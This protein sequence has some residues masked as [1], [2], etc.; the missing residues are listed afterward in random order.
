VGRAATSAPPPSARAG[1]RSPPHGGPSWTGTALRAIE[2]DPLSLDPTF[3]PG[4]TDLA[5]ALEHVGRYGEAVDAFLRGR[6]VAGRPPSPS[7][8]LAMLLFRAGRR[9]EAWAMIRAAED[10]QGPPLV[11]PWGVASFYA[12]VSEPRR[13]LDWLER[14][15]A[16]RDGALVWLKVHPRLDGIRGEPRYMD[17]LARMRLDT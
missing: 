13:A 12:V 10:R 7:P 4:H 1:R 8:G 17:L 2:L 16:Q 3:E 6:E 9:D 15:H 14:A 5:R 11:S